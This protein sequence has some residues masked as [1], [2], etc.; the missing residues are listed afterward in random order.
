MD[1][2]FLGVYRKLIE[3]Q[4]VAILIRGSDAR[5]SENRSSVSQHNVVDLTYTTGNNPAQSPTM[6]IVTFKAR[7]LTDP[8]FSLYEFHLG[9]TMLCLQRS[10]PSHGHLQRNNPVQPSPERLLFRVRAH[11]LDRT[12]ANNSVVW[13]FHGVSECHGPRRNFY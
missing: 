1:H 10:E 12:F 2:D 6:A 5:S 7:R 11:L 13:I 4:S 8:F 9:S 3:A